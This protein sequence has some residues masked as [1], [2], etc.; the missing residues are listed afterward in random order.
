MYK[1]GSDDLKYRI[2][3]SP[4]VVQVKCRQASTMVSQLCDT[5]VLNFNF[6]DLQKSQRYPFNMFTVVT[7]LFYVQI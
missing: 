2:S 1:K 6:D 4:S 5:L 3:K 7:S